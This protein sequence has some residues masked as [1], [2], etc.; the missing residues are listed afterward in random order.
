M[1]FLSVCPYRIRCAWFGVTDH[2]AVMANSAVPKF[3][4]PVHRWLLGVTLW[5]AQT[6]HWALHS[7]KQSECSGA[8]S[9]GLLTILDQFCRHYL[10][11]AASTFLQF[12]GGLVTLFQMGV[13]PTA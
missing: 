11:V 8:T 6:G 9:D 5:I 12:A 2:W 1:I 10:T 7:V 3:F 4:F 13:V